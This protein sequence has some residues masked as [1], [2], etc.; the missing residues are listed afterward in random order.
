VKQAVHRKYLT[1]VAQEDAELAAFCRL[2]AG[3]GARSFLEI[4]SRYGGSLWRVAHALP[5]GSRIVSI[6]LPEGF[7]GRGDGAVNLQACIDALNAEGYD[8]HV[9]WGKSNAPANIAQAKALGPFDAV[10]IDGDHT[11]QACTAD[12][13]NYGPMARIVAF[14]DIAWNRPA[15]H[16]G[17]I[18][19]APILWA[20]VRKQ[21]RHVEFK[22]CPTGRNNGIGVLW[23][24]A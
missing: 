11:L 4:G 1:D 14:H 16:T 8:A 20:K 12:F 22:F 23:R 24:S 2:L 10:F 5:K 21:Y 15:D 18:I 7:G 3:E 9:I 17:A 13:E 6:E 19:E